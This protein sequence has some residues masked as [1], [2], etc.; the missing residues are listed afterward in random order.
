QTAITRI[1]PHRETLFVVRRLG[2]GQNGFRVELQ[3][4]TRSCDHQLNREPRLEQAWFVR[5]LESFYYA[6]QPGGP[7]ERQRLFALDTHSMFEGEEERCQL[8]HVVDVKVADDKVS[9][10]LPRDTIPSERM[11]SS[12]AAVHHDADARGLDEV[13]GRIPVAVWHACSGSENRQL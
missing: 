11:N 9:H 3:A 1:D 4:V 13:S 5:R 8:A 10:P 7:D 2:Y 12:G 6:F